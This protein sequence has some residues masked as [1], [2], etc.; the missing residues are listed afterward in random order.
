MKKTELFCSSAVPF[1][2]RSYGG[3]RQAARTDSAVGCVSVCA[4]LCMDGEVQQRVRE[5]GGG[6]WLVGVQSAQLKNAETIALYPQTL[7]IA[8]H[9]CNAVQEFRLP[10]S[11]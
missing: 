4:R 10:S 8:L 11:V 3:D 9:F 6:G 7:R 1:N 2:H 5:V